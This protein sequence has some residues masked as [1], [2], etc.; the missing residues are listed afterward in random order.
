MRKISNRNSNKIIGKIPNFKTGKMVQYES[1]LERDYIFRLL[2]D[3][4]V[5]SF[6]HQPLALQYSLDGRKRRYTPDFLVIE[7]NNHMIVEV[8]PE[9]KLPQYENKFKA[10]KSELYNLGYQ[11]E[12]VTDRQIRVE[13]QLANIKFLYRYVDIDISPKCLLNTANYFK[14]INTYLFIGRALVALKKIGISINEF[15]SMMFHRFIL[16]DITEKITPWAKISFNHQA[17]DPYK[18]I[19]H[20]EPHSCWAKVYSKESRL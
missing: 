17:I 5:Q 7:N 2:Y 15:Y 11:F 8:K 14:H 18:E 19:D 9:E 3:S 16:F 20:D 4:K 10:I 13:P 12:V 6:T 1:Q